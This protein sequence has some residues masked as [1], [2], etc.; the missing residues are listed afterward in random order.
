MVFVAALEAGPVRNGPFV[1]PPSYWPHVRELCDRHGTLLIFDEIPTGLGK[2]GVL[3]SGQHTGARSDVTVIGKALGGA[4][5]PIAAVIVH[6]SLD[7]TGKLDL[8]YYTHER[9]PLCAAA[10]LATLDVIEE[11]ALVTRAARIGARTLERLSSL[12][13][14]CPHFGRVRGVE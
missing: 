10:G 9:N 11:E 5:M 2:T 7:T 3:F 4:A 14:R 1:P 6:Q 8:G 13:A 12:V